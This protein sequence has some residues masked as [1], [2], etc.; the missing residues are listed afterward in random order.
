MTT[1]RTRSQIGRSSRN[2]GATVERQLAAWLRGHGWPHAERGRNN[3]FATAARSRGDGYDIDGCPGLLFDAKSTTDR[4]WLVPAWL[5]ELA[6]DA[7][8]RGLLPILVVKQ[9]GHTDPGRWWAWL[10]VSDLYRAVYRDPAERFA[11][12]VPMCLELGH[13]APLLHAAGYGEA[14]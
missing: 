8:E 12:R 7:D 1:T 9:A 5:R 10:L 14:P 13:L 2:K 11:E 6:D 3:G 4:P